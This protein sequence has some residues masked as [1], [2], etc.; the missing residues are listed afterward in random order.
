MS[1]KNETSINIQKL[2]LKKCTQVGQITE[3]LIPTN[4]MR[5]FYVPQPGT[6]VITS[7]ILY[8][9]GSRDE[10]RGETGIAHMLEH[11]LFKPT[12]HDIERGTEA[13][14]TMFERDAGIIL[15]A[16]TWKDRTTYFFTYPKEHFSR[17]LSIEKERMR[18]VVLTDDV[19]KPEQTNVL[20]EFDMYAGDEFFSLAT[21]MY[22]VAFRSHTYGHETIGYREDI[23]AFTVEKL[24]A[25][26][27]TY[28]MPNNASLI[29]VGD[30]SEREM[31]QNVLTH[32]GDM[33]R[34]PDIQRITLHEPKQE[35]VRTITLKRPSSKHILALGVKHSPF[36]QVHWFETM[37]I[38][39][40]LAGGKDSVLY[41]KFID[42]GFVS[43]FEISVEESREENLALI[44]CTL[45]RKTTHLKLEKALRETIT[46]LTPVVIAPYL[47]KTIAK[48]LMSECLSRENS[49][50]F[51][52]ELTEYISTD[53]WKQFYESEN[54]LKKISPQGIRKQMDILFAE[55]NTT[56]GYFIGTK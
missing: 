1:K 54:I 21:E 40:M 15:N 13:S 37:V 6:G 31:K 56:I 23:E 35:G 42:T 34:G 14:V 7:S 8:Q 44:F 17:A 20:S 26:Y 45:T 47:K 5:V 4:G 38:F 19:L 41:K 32:F 9:V 10:A 52:S 29:I 50:K 39:D 12:I 27:D 28:Y 2:T 46:G 25:F 3:Y 43:G 16:N 18:D 22:D 33:S 24:R 30:V 53:A 11:M 48:L 55:E 51:T 36:P 49:M